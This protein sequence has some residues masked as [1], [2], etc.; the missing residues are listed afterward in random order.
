MLELS[1][2]SLAGSGCGPERPCIVTETI[3]DQADYF[4]KELALGLHDSALPYDYVSG[5]AFLTVSR[6]IHDAYCGNDERLR[7]VRSAGD[8]PPMDRSRVVRGQ[9]LSSQF[10][11]RRSSSQSAEV[12]KA[13]VRLAEERRQAQKPKLCNS[14]K[15]SALKP[16]TLPKTLFHITIILINKAQYNSRTRPWC[17]SSRWAWR[18]ASRRHRV[19]GIQKTRDT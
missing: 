17:P 10:F 14:P 12:K 6:R 7:L 1:L 3:L 4:L 8:A 19:V 11:A 2:R 16:K 13:E 5:L 9:N 15:P 18:P